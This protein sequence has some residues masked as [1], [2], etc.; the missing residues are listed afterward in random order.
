MVE[1]SRSGNNCVIKGIH[2]RGV[3]NPRAGAG[4]VCHARIYLIRS[5]REAG[6]SPGVTDVRDIIGGN[7]LTTVSA[8]QDRDVMEEARQKVGLVWKKTFQIPMPSNIL[9]QGP[10]IVQYKRF[11]TYIKLNKLIHFDDAET[12]DPFGGLYL[13]YDAS[14]AVAADEPELRFTSRVYFE[15]CN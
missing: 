10:S 9:E 11:K 12:G 13:Y 8:F 6:D 15:N 3:I 7:G 14:T 1:N 5:Q 4:A 2:L